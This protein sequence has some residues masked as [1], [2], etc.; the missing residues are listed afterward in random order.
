[1]LTTLDSH[2]RKADVKMK[3]MIIAAGAAATTAE[4]SVAGKGILAWSDSINFSLVS[5]SLEKTFNKCIGLNAKVD[6]LK[7]IHAC[8][9]WHF[10][11]LSKT[12]Y[13]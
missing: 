12:V 3:I 7:K 10:P 6:T 13:K 5:Q 8:L 11:P 1:M 9:S 2:R 4:R